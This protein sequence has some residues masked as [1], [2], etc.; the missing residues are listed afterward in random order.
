METRVTSAKKEVVIGDE[1][2]TVL[3]GER[4]NP[5]GK[6]R[7]AAAL[8]AGDLE[9]V[10]QEAIAQV[11]A[12]ADVLDVNVGLAGLD[13]AALLPQAVQVVMETVDVPLCLDSHDPKALAAALRVYRGKAIV[14]SVNGQETALNEVLPLVKE[15]GAAVIGLTMDDEGIPQSAERRV[16]IAHRIVE[17]A[18][19]LGI[20][21]EDIIM[22]CLALTIGTDGLAAR[23]TLETIR[24]VKAELGIN[25]TLGA[26]NI[27]FGLPDRDILNGA[28]L[29]LAIAAGVTCPTVDVA[30]VGSAVLAT[31]LLLGRD[32]YARRYIRAFRQRQTQA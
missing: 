17:R 13:E 30:R 10:R 11:Q 7:L 3:I 8:Q 24:R 23:V 25:Q 1:R 31:D 26:S 29:A 20:P 27:S 28:F 9:L 16:A 32:E 2:P 21:R 19:T 4:I 22:D 18:A 12:G 15:Y 6:K 5:S 14:N